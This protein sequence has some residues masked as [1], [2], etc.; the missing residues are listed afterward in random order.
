MKKTVSILLTLILVM[1]LFAGCGEPAA[2]RTTMNIYAIKGPT[3]IGMVSLMEADA[4]GTAKHDYNFTVV[5]EPTAVIGKISSKEADIAAVPTNMA[6]ALYKKTSGGITVLALNTSG[7]LFIMEKGN[8]I[9]SIAD[10]KGKTVYSTGQGANPEFAINYILK[11]NNL[12]VGT[13]VKVEYL[14][15]ND[16]LVAKLKTNDDAILLAPQPAAATV[17]AKVEGSR[18][19]IDM[20]K[21]FEKAAGTDMYMGCIVV[22]NEFL[23][24]NE[25]AV[26]E[27]LKE[28]EAS[29]KAV[30]EDTDGAATL[31]EKYQIIPSAAIAK[32][33]IPQSGVCY[34]D[35]EDMKT[36]LSAYLN[37]CKAEMPKLIGGEVPGEAFYYT[38][39]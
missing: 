29:V 39:K 5:G 15:Q 23:E 1:G 14:A 24:K 7:N 31:C 32:K 8:T 34:V 30:L 27:F 12:T 28:Y 11:K 33:A 2:Q 26:K 36:A 10:L 16:E 17:L 20:T 21:E 22:R 38:G 9:S 35:G 18:L 6:S 13:D 4:N 37:I 19:A 25:A 3:G